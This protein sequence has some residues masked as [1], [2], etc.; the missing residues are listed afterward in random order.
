MANPE[1]KRIALWVSVTGLLASN[2]DRDGD[3]YRAD[4]V[5]TE[6][7]A[8]RALMREAADVLTMFQVLSTPNNKAHNSLA[9]LIKRQEA[10]DD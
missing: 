5:D 7:D 1:L 3:W 8:N 6:L 9:D 4:P 10:S 2:E